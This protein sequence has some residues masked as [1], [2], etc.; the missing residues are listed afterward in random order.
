ME[1]IMAK[2]EITGKRAR[3]GNNVSH[4]NNKTK[5]RFKANIQSV[6]AVD[7]KGRTRRMKV[8][9]SALRSGLVT[10]ALPRRVEMELLKE[11]ENN[12]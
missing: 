6:K 1:T 8:S 12:G 11:Q 2:C 5:R 3:T 9:T 7:E 10:K 4:A